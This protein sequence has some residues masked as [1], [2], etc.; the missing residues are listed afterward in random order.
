[1]AIHAELGLD[2]EAAEVLDEL[3]LIAAHAGDGARAARLASAAAAA[4]ADLECAPLPGMDGRLSAAR[5]RLVKSGSVGCWETA[6]AEGEA[7]TLADAIKYARRGR[8]PR[9]R[10]ADGW[11]SLTPVELEVARLA[12]S[13]ISNVE[14]A[15]QLFIARGTVKMHLSS[16]YQKLE[17]ANRTEL[18]AALTA[19]GDGAET[20][21]TRIR[22]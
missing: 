7:I 12:A 15:A 2:R 3:A 22:R 17:V 5:E 6:W 19:R 13:G 9:D 1:M 11:D 16:V 20:P 8:G 18:A 21:R 4:R 10:P 14:I